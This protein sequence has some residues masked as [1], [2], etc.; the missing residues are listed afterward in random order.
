MQTSSNTFFLA[1]VV[2]IILLL[3]LLASVLTFDLSEHRL[4]Q[5]VKASQASFDAFYDAHP[6]S[7]ILLYF[8]TY[9][10]AAALSLPGAA[11]LSVAGG[12]M[13]GLTLGT[14]LASFASTI[15]ATL[16]FLIAR[17]LFRD[18]IT[19][20]F[21]PAFESINRGVERGGALY[22]ISLRLVPALPYFVTNAGMGLT[23]MRIHTY[24]WASQVGM[25][26][27]TIVYVNAGTQ[28]ARI[29]SLGSIMSP[30]LVASFVLLAALPV[31]G[32]AIV[33]VID[34]R[35]CSVAQQA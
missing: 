10:L 29:N 4:L 16:A 5:V 11:V 13:F 22:L 12:A 24:Y 20:R 17:H 6:I 30:G 34:R 1:K 3:G 19:A 32:K 2:V 23:R 18:W 25:L 31:A 33:R 14:L 15:G 8:G 9:V 35:R 27:G 26:A 28:L 21:T 7:A